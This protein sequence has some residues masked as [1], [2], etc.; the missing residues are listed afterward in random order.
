MSATRTDGCKRVVLTHDSGASDVVI[1][2]S[3]AR[4]LPI[5]HSSKDGIEHEVAS[6]GVSVHLFER[7][8][9]VIMPWDSIDTPLLM[10]C[11]VVEVHKPL[12][13]VTCLVAA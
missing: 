9:N 11:R 1:P 2:S 5:H 10:S 7:Y 4:N 6:G 13:A 8:A 12:L 3:V